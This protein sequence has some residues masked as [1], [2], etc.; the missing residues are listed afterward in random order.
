VLLAVGA[1]QFWLSFAGPVVMY[2]FIRWIS[3]VPFTEQQ[4]LRTR[5]DDYR[6]YQR[7]TPILF[8]WFPSEPSPA[9]KEHNP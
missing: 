2:V 1:P 6:R 8:P 9:D 3:G 5:G 4:A 7:S